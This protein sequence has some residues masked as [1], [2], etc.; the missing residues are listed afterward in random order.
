[1]SGWIEIVLVVGFVAAC[2][3]LAGLTLSVFIALVMK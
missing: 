1:M 3:A 2:L